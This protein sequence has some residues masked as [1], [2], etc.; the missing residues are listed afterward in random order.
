MKTIWKF[1]LKVE[2]IQ[3][4]E[5]P[6]DAKI[7]CVQVKQGTPCLWAEVDSSAPKEERAIE[8]FGT[9]H[10]IF[11]DMGIDREY[12]STFQMHEGALV[13]HAYEYKGV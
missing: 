4:L 10:E 13:F 5:M 2:D 7:L 9:G 11:Y 6:K 12:I 8:I 1:E 3:R